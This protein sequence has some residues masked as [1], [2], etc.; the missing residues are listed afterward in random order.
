M[1]EHSGTTGLPPS[2]LP[3]ACVIGKEVRVYGP[4]AENDTRP[5][6]YRRTFPHRGHALQ[7]AMLHDDSNKPMIKGY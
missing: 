2:A 3:V 6:R 7:W 4:V 5:L 1:R